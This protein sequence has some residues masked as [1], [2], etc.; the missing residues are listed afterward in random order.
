MR[1]AL[2][3]LILVAG[4]HAQEAS[5][6]SELAAPESL[7]GQRLLLQIDILAPTF[8]SGSTHFD[9]PETPGLVIMPPAG[10]PVVGSE[11]ID[12]HSFTTRRHE[13][14]IFAIRPGRHRL[15]AIGIRFATASRQ[16]RP[17]E[18]HRLA[19][20]P[21]SFLATEAPGASGRILTVTDELEASQ[22]WEPEETTL[23]VGDAVT[24][25]VK[26]RA[27]DVPAM[28]LPRIPFAE[29]D[30]LAIYRRPP[31]ASN[32]TGRGEL[33]GE[34]IESATYVCERAGFLVLPELVIAWW[35]I[36]TRTIERAVLPELTLTVENAL[37]PQTSGLP[38]TRQ[39]TS[40][41][42]WTW[43]ALTF[44]LAAIGVSLYWYLSRRK[45]ADGEPARFASLVVACREDNA[46]EALVALYRWMDARDAASRPTTIDGLIKEAP[47]RPLASEF[48]FL[49]RAVLERKAAWSGASLASS[50]SRSRKHHQNE[51]RAS[52]FDLPRLNPSQERSR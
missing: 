9:L 25:Y 5:I 17:P 15:S 36:E 47:Y 8:F 51:A 3:A 19:T 52:G 31:A 1:S 23:R 24:R 33:T 29:I 30:G 14:S 26:L 12:G 37:E 21:V 38:A 16:G 42:P 11:T 4:L 22:T 39:E 43:I 41:I 40:G 13:L 6:R 44:M 32:R 34:R 10:S 28:L 2:A 49:V 18:G 45:R 50:L 48:E 35:N 46:A 7:V 27:R 20:E